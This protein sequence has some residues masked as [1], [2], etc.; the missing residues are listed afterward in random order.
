MK[1]RALPCLPENPGPLKPPKLSLIV[2][3]A[4][5]RQNRLTNVPNKKCELNYREI[6]VGRGN[7]VAAEK[8]RLYIYDPGGVGANFF[9]LIFSAVIILGAR[10]GRSNLLGSNHSQIYL[11]MRAKLGRIP[12]VVSK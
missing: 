8:Q 10:G 4:E 7:S 9:L 5:L 11:R 6:H 3:G 1:N 2:T 12:T